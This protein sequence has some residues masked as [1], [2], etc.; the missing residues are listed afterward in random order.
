MLCLTCER[1]ERSVRAVTWPRDDVKLDA[2]AR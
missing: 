2:F 1:R